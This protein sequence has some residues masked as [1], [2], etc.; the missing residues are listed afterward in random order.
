MSRQRHPY[1]DGPPWP[2]VLQTKETVLINRPPRTLFLTGAPGLL[3]PYLLRDLLLEGPALALLVR[4][5]RNSA[6]NL[7]FASILYLPLLLGLLVATLR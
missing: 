5:D 4:R 1:N 2:A 3:G 7:F 6:R